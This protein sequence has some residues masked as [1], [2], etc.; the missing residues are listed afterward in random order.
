MRNDGDE[1]HGR[2]PAICRVAQKHVKMGI[3]TDPRRCDPGLDAAADEP[4][5]A[6]QRCP[7][8]KASH[9]PKRRPPHIDEHSSQG[10]Y[11]APP[12]YLS[13]HPRQ[14]CTWRDV[15]PEKRR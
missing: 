13:E 11:V 9:S 12:T 15:R 7:R 4:T 10:R 3:W 14:D 8:F 2:N 5:R 6:E 1:G